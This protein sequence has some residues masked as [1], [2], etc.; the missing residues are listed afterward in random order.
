MGQP[1]VCAGP[2]EVR[3]NGKGTAD[4]RFVPQHSWGPSK[5]DTGLEI[6]PTIEAVIERAASTAL[7]GEFDSTGS[8]VV[9]GLLIVGLDPRS[10]SLIAKTEVQG[11]AFRH[12][13]SVFRVEA[14]DVVGL[15]PG[16]AGADSATDLIRKAEDGS[17][18]PYPAPVAA[19]PTVL[20]VKRP[21]KTIP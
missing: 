20:L 3:R 21:S 11:Q 1:Q 7:I 9:V 14:D 10:E 13:P 8:E 4:D 17:A 5:T 15:P 12:P 6:S 16:F 2:F 19:L 18:A